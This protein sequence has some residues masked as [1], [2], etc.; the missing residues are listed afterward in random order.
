MFCY[1][2]INMNIKCLRRCERVFC[3]YCANLSVE[4]ERKEVEKHV[5]GV[6]AHIV[7]KLLSNLG[8]TSDF[9]NRETVLI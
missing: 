1:F 2:G 4:T 5:P 9:N 3:G 7:A 8:M 6:V